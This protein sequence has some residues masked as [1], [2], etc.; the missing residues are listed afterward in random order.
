MAV[1]WPTAVGMI[2]AQM[3]S[4]RL[5]LPLLSFGG[6]QQKEANLG[7]AGGST[8][9]GSAKDAEPHAHSQ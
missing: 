5:S 2:A 3:C 1:R 4:H 9:T 7:G 8:G 6:F